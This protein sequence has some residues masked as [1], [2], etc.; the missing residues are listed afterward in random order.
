MSG[1]NGD[2]DGKTIPE[3]YPETVM[4]YDHM[5][6]IE[7]G[8]VV[9]Y[10]TLSTIIGR[11]VQTKGRG[12]LTTACWWLLRRDDIL[13]EAVR[14]IGMRHMPPSETVKVGQ[15]AVKRM[16]RAARR[17]ALKVA[18]VGPDGY[19]DLDAQ[20]KIQHNILLSQLGAVR[21]FT[22]HHAQKRLATAIEKTQEQLPLAKMLEAF[23]G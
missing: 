15:N 12:L 22:G 18:S 13:F 5:K 10:A 8:V 3:A 1:S 4:L 2:G 20:E 17:G 14:G 9:D 23:K 21:H 11:D 6:E 16:H 7:V 19:A